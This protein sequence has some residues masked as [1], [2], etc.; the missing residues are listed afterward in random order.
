[1]GPAH[2]LLLLL[3]ER[4]YSVALVDPWMLRVVDLPAALEQRGW[5]AGVRAELRLELSDDVLPENAGRWRLSVAEGSARVARLAP[6]A[7][8]AARGSPAPPVLRLDV[9]GLA[10]LYSGHLSPGLLQQ[11]GL[12]DGDAAALELAA[13]LFAGPAP[14]MADMF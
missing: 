5:P 4:H 8:S 14:A 7:P 13:A 12:L 2:P 9:R 3:A 6:G 10:A 1:G 11:A